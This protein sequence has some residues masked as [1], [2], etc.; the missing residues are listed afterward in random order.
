MTHDD[1]EI[2]MPSV[3]AVML[4][5]R[6]AEQRGMLVAAL[7]L[8][9]TLDGLIPGDDVRASQLLRCDIRT[10]RRIKAGLLDLGGFEPCAGGIRPDRRLRHAVR[11][12]KQSNRKSIPRSDDAAILAKTGG[13]CSYCAVELSMKLGLPS[14]FHRDHA[15]A[16]ASGGTNDIGLLVPS[17]AACNAA[18][19]KKTVV[20]WLTGR[21]AV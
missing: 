3:M 4:Q 2:D 18:K 12:A 14:S 10:Y 19:G 17:C 16:V 5:T 15:F 7:V 20:E 1:I 13:K 8:A 6:S 11:W 21:T 9:H